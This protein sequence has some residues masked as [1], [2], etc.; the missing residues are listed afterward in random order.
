MKPDFGIDAPGLVR[1]LF[2]I[3]LDGAICAALVFWLLGAG[4]PWGLIPLSLPILVTIYALGMGSFMIYGSKIMKISDSE[5][6]LD[7]LQ[8]TGNEMA[9]DVGCG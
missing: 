7:R 2:L 9:L 8:W 6:L 3:G 1:T 5:R 4:Y